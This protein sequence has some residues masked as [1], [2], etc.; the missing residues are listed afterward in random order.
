M[1]RLRMNLS[2]WFDVYLSKSASTRL[3]KFKLVEPELRGVEDGVLI[4][5]VVEP[6]LAADMGRNRYFLL[7]SDELTPSQLQEFKEHI[8]RACRRDVDALTV[9][10]NRDEVQD[11]IDRVRRAC[12]KWERENPGRGIGEDAATPQEKGAGVEARNDDREDVV[13]Y[14]PKASQK[15]AGDGVGIRTWFR[16]KW[17]VAYV[18]IPIVGAYLVLG[19][20]YWHVTGELK[21]IEYS[22]EQSSTRSDRKIANFV[23]R[24]GRTE[25][26]IEAI[27]EPR[28]SKIEEVYAN[29][30][31]D[32]VEEVRQEV[33]ALDARITD[34]E[35]FD[36][37]E[38]SAKLSHLEAEQT[39]I[40]EDQIGEDR[41][42][43]ESL[44]VEVKKFEHLEIRVRLL[45]DWV[46]NMIGLIE[47]AD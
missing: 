8:L 9:A 29:T 26:W 22:I 19:L 17:V 40:V 7:M 37:A 46:N 33:V 16:R 43:E 32:D 13:H 21:D 41:R 18:V 45:E 30:G 23:D 15:S 28:I 47:N 1:I 25:S 11:H 14:D 27:A 39:K 5:D 2:G 38:L 4:M 42:E 36:A 10:R 20:G 35:K 6:R 31:S 44:Y 24:I 3:R 34:L 12:M